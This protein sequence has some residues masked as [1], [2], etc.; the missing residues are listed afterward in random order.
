MSL[1]ISE[2]ALRRHRHTIST[3]HNIDPI[4]HTSQRHQNAYHGR[5]LDPKTK[6]RSVSPGLGQK[7]QTQSSTGSIEKPWE[8]DS[9]PLVKQQRLP[10]ST[11]LKYAG[12]GVNM[13]GFFSSE[14]ERALMGE[15]DEARR[16]FYSQQYQQGLQMSASQQHYGLQSP[17][18]SVDQTGAAPSYEDQ[19]THWGATNQLQGVDY[20]H[21]D[22]SQA[23]PSDW[24][25]LHTGETHSTAGSLSAGEGYPNSRSPSPNPSDLANYGIQNEDRHTWRCAYPGCASKAIF[26][27]G[28]DLRKHYRRHSKNFFCR[29]EGCPQATE[30]GF[31]SKKDRARHEAKHNPG[32]PCEAAGCDR[33]FSRQDNM[34]DHVRRIHK[35][36]SC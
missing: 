2:S 24:T 34:K 3:H 20:L 16:L 9:T 17:C 8:L 31:S 6:Y 26:V 11:Y 14:A 10:L 36:A 28:C 33:V 18:I 4:Y 25:S 32:V 27:R 12:A 22:S 29:H 21:S 30:G 15:E 5:Y 35:S 23:G 13:S 19:D 7:Y 1:S